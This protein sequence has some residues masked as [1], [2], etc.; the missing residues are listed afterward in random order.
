MQKDPGLRT[1]YLEGAV[2]GMR[3]RTMGSVPYTAHAWKVVPWW[4]R[5][6][7]Q[8]PAT[9]AVRRHDSGYRSG[10]LRQERRA[11]NVTVV[12]ASQLLA[13]AASADCCAGESDPQQDGCL[14]HTPPAVAAG[15]GATISATSSSKT[16]GT[17][18]GDGVTTPVENTFQTPRFNAL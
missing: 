5:M 2:P 13:T 4:Q 6:T 18:Y 16:R 12:A 17:A 15:G 3:L 8:E 1:C 11:T 9:H 10:N 14:S 7:F